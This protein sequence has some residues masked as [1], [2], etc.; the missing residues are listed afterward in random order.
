M[1][2]KCTA[3]IPTY[4]VEKYIIEAIDS[5]IEQTWQ[6]EKIII[7]DDGSV[8]NT[9]TLIHSHFATQI[10]TGQILLHVLTQNSGVSI[11][12]NKGVELAESDWILFLD[13]DDVLLPDALS[14]LI[15]KSFELNVTPNQPYHLIQAAYQLIDSNSEIVSESFTW[16]QVN[17]DETLGWIFY[18]NHISTSGLLVNREHF[19]RLGGFD[20]GLAYCEDWDL[21]V[22]FAHN[23]GIGYVDRTLIN[24]RRHDLNSSNSMAVMHEAERYVLQRYKL[25]EIKSAIMLRQCSYSKNISDFISILYRLDEWECGFDEVNKAKSL[26]PDDNCLYFFSGLYFLKKQLYE[27][28]LVEFEFGEINSSTNGAVLNNLG[29]INLCL[30]HRDKA[31]KYINMALILHSNYMDALKNKKLLN[32]VCIDIEKVTFTWRELRPVLINY[33]R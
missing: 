11:A 21:W 32:D 29:A 2:I 27:K 3:V 14:L 31:E 17:F 15:K 18:R 23:S 7:V 19:N 20:S 8:D 13:A 25:D 9:I 24:V 10:K 4:N 33:S 22:R 30:G 12:R 1:N 5:L 26:T 28:A 16:R 6:L